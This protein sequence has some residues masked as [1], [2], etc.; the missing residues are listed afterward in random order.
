MRCP[1]PCHSHTQRSLLRGHL[2]S[3]S[4]HHHTWRP[5]PQ[6]VQAA[7]TH[8]WDPLPPSLL[9]SSTGGT[10][11]TMG[12]VYRRAEWDLPTGEAS[13]HRSHILRCSWPWTRGLISLGG[14][15]LICRTGRLTL[16]P[17]RV[18]VGPEERQG[19]GR[20]ALWPVRFLIGLSPSLEMLYAPGFP[21]RHLTHPGST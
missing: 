16:P 3:L 18:A 6:T 20:V 1:R 9:L 14:A 13:S 21:G 19:D 11:S 12:A 8:L 15:V 2:S 17:R 7:A 5:G 4:T 10:V